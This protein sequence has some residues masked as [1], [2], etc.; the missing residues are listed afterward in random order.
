MLRLSQLNLFPMEKIS[1][2]IRTTTVQEEAY[3][4]KNELWFRVVLDMQD[5]GGG[6][7]SV[8]LIAQSTIGDPIQVTVSTVDSSTKE[9]LQLEWI[10][11]EIETVT[12]NEVTDSEKTKKQ[13]AAAS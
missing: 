4:E 3:L 9:T 1:L 13:R 10:T 2:N 12:S 11:T 7:Y 8:S 6:Q 5:L